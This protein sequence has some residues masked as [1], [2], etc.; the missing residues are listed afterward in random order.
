M[1]KRPVTAQ[2]EVRFPCKH[3]QGSHTQPH[4]SPVV[5]FPC[6]WGRRGENSNVT[7][8]RGRDEGTQGPQQQPAAALQ[9]ASLALLKVLSVESQTAMIA[10][11]EEGGRN[12]HD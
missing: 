7:H 4:F 6:A 8:I 12:G 11:A 9:E 10:K 5:P 1:G 3:S 2:A